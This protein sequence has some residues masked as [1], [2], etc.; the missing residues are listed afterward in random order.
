[1]GFEVP[2]ALLLYSNFLEGAGSDSV[3][4]RLGV[5]PAPSAWVPGH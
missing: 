2:V 4:N 1:M 3:S 5:T